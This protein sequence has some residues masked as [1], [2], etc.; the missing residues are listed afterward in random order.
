MDKRE[1]HY[2][3][4]GEAKVLYL[5]LWLQ[6]HPL[7]AWEFA[8]EDI[9]RFIGENQ[10]RVSMILRPLMEA[11]YVIPAKI[12]RTRGERGPKRI[13]EVQT[14]SFITCRDTASLVLEL[15]QFPDKDEEGK[16][17]LRSFVA[18]LFKAPRKLRY[19]SEED[20]MGGRFYR[21]KINELSES[22][23]HIE[24]VSEHYV[25]PRL[26]VYLER[27]YL[28]LLELSP[29]VK[30]LPGYTFHSE[31]DAWSLDAPE[32]QR[33]QTPKESPRQVPRVRSASSN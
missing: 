3:S 21:G 28:R 8:Q 16:I 32:S 1:Y 11:G 2:L 27:R 23:E 22:G 15:L 5:I 29:H 33:R 9:G 31:R 19:L 10:S 25:R 7:Q 12:S 20:L 24:R 4:E 30:D 17:D 18:H 14:K 6:H 26:R 13:Y